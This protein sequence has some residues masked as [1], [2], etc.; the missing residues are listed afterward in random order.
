M[1]L[2][3]LFSH[4]HQKREGCIE[5]TY[6]EGTWS[7]KLKKICQRVA[8]HLLVLI[9]GRHIKGVIFA[10]GSPE[11]KV[12]LVN[13]T[14]V[15]V[16]FQNGVKEGRCFKCTHRYFVQVHVSQCKGCSVRD[17]RGYRFHIEKWRWAVSACSTVWYT[18]KMIL[19]WP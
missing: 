5:S 13:F 3:K 1:G 9:K 8:Y 18:W 10:C 11:K 19:F 14:N 17:F 6:H 4:M 15:L 12:C 2:E 16:H 7:Q